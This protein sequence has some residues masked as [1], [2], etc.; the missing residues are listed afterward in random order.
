MRTIGIPSRAMA[1]ASSSD[2][3]T[4]IPFSRAV[5]PACWITGP[6]ASGSE[7]GMPISSAA[8][9]DVASLFPTSSDFFLLG[10][11]A[12]MYATSFRSPFAR[13]AASS[14]AV[15][16]F[17]GALRFDRVHVL[18]AAPREADEDTA[19]GTELAGD[20]ACLMQRVRRLERGHDAFEPGAELE[21]GDRVLVPDRDV[22]HALEI[23]QEGVL[24]T[25]PGI[26]EPGRDRVRVED[27]AVAVLQEVRVGA[28]QHAWAPGHER[29]GVLPAPDPRAGGLD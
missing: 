7:N 24:G 9:P 23:T 13:S 10:W 16:V 18:V 19:A 5:C 1:A 21:R 4:V 11:P 14:R 29:S 12:I 3:P 20:H 2:A 28:M 25:Y 17:T 8:I 15:S 22:V 6:S 27:L 26:V